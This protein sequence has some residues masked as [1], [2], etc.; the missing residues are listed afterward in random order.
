MNNI[1]SNDATRIRKVIGKSSY[2]ELYYHW[3]H[4]VFGKILCNFLIFVSISFFLH[5][6]A[7]ADNIY[8]VPVPKA[9]PLRQIGSCRLPEKIA[10]GRNGWH[11][12]EI[13]IYKTC[14]NQFERP[15]VYAFCFGQL[16][17]IQGILVFEIPRTLLYSFISKCFFGGCVLF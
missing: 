4:F 5:F 11:T 9:E 17:K 15:Q 12:L 16:L 3:R 2:S 14:V 8:Q 6:I 13:C 7:L 1:I 10:I